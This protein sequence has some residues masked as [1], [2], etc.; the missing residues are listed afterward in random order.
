MAARSTNRSPAP[1]LVALDIHND[2]AKLTQR[3]RLPD[4]NILTDAPLGKNH[5]ANLHT[6]QK[7]RKRL[8]C[9]QAMLESGKAVV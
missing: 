5:I 9:L 8:P 3:I 7:K 6:S 2:A 4:A 1:L